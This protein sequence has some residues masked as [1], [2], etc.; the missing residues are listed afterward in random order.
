M[1]KLLRLITFCLVGL[2]SQAQ[3]TLAPGDI[4]FL[5]HNADSSDEFAFILLKDVDGATTIT[6]TDCGWDGAS[7][8]CTSGD[9][10]GVTW[11][12][13]APLTCGTVI[14]I[15]PITLTV[16]GGGSASGSY[17]QYSSIG[18]QLLA[19]QGSAGSPTFISAISSS[20]TTGMTDANWNGSAATNQTTTLPTGLT[21]GVNCIRL[22]IGGSSTSQGSE[23]DNW[24]YDCST[25]S[26]TIDDVRTAINNVGNWNND[27]SMAFSPAAPSC[28][29][30]VTCAPAC[31]DPDVPTPTANINNV[32][33]STNVTLDWAGDSLNDATN[34]HIYT[35]A[36]GVTQLTTTASSSLVVTPSVTTTYYIRGEDGAGCVDESTGPCGSVTVTVD[37][38]SS[39]LISATASTNNVC[40]STSVNLTANGLSLGSG[41]TF[42]WYTGSGGT[43][44]NLGSSNPLNV[45]PATTTT[46]YAYVT[47]TCNT[48]EESITVTI[49]APVIDV[50]GNTTSIA[51]GDTIPDVSD[52]TD[53]GTTAT[54]V[55]K[56]YTID[57]T[58]G[59]ETLTITSIISSGTNAGEFVVGS[60]PTTITAGNTDTFTVTFT[61]TDAGTRTATITINN[62]DCVK[63]AYDFAIQGTGDASLSTNEVSLLNQLSNIYPN[64]NKGSFTLNY[65]GQEQLKELLVVDLLGKRVQTISLENFDNSQ[66]I[67]LTALAKGM[68]FITIQSASAKVTKRMII[69]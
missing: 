35:T 54:S 1:K 53:F 11:S 44:S 38:T 52:D 28:A 3:T 20:E 56:T 15:T 40:P 68:Y 27:N 16:T 69:E 66:E 18:D 8:Q 13:G 48:L 39:T 42:T 2:T 64:P 60:V 41:A 22:R 12:S 61:P 24:Q 47:G 10:N 45:S 36:C 55:M 9:L 26:G 19:Y 14:N 32:C 58:A 65:S 67:N 21:T 51:D 31:T 59:T 62:N 43:G 46:Y 29:W 50:Q 5:G 57:N 7:F 23:A 34:W 25:V 17:T 63:F 4:A 37:Q 33:P 30:S 49:T 6:F